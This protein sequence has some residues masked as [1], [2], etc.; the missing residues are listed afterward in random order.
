[1][2]EWWTYRLSDFLLFSPDTY[3]R[4]IELCHRAVW[5]L[6][7]LTALAGIVILVLAARGRTVLHGRIIALLLAAVWLW[8]AWDFLLHRYATI[9]W[10][11]RWFAAS[12]ALEALLLVAFGVVG[13]RLTRGAITPN[14]QRIGLAIFVFALFLHP[15]VGVLV[16]RQW[17]QVEL[18]G[19][20][21]D[22]TALA[23]LGIIHF[24]A[25]KRRLVLLIIPLSWCAVSGA[26]L[27]AMQA[28]DALLLPATVGVML[29]AS[30]Y[31][32]WVR[33]RGGL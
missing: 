32:W 8:V 33:R 4:L 7:L 23:T 22:C 27:R 26:T 30:L 19:I 17:M 13:T 10:A 11:S 1:M 15:F 24:L 31:A 6:Q 2:S 20:T 16:G 28:P 12:F 9:N 25:Q 14:S 5:P 3:F 29:L 21:P 18:F